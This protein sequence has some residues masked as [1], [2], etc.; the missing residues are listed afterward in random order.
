[1]LKV[2]KNKIN[3]LELF[4]NFLKESSK[5]NQA[6]Y[7]ACCGG[8]WDDDDYYGDDEYYNDYWWQLYE[9]EKKQQEREKKKSESTVWDKESGQFIPKEEYDLKQAFRRGE[10][11]EE[12]LKH[13]RK[14][15]KRGGRG[16][17]SKKKININEIEDYSDDDN[18]K[19]LNESYNKQRYIKFYPN[20]K[21][22]YNFQS[23]ETIFELDD[24]CDTEGY[25]VSKSTVSYILDHTTLHCT[26]VFNTKGKMELVVAKSFESLKDSVA[27]IERYLDYKYDAND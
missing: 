25:V 7:G 8:F 21:D 20:V 26:A 15:N 1:M 12:E 23:M 27:E 14:R 16:S 10:I 3:F 11:D 4:N 18:E 2:S 24:M 9:E 22:K 6:M 13:G 5:V 19:V 17:K